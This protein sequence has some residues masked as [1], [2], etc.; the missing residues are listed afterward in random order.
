LRYLLPGRNKTAILLLIENHY[1]IRKKGPY[2]DHPSS[3]KMEISE[4]ASSA[5]RN[6]CTPRREDFAGKTPDKVGDIR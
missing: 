6:E 4:I 1:I 2:E 5:N 3:L